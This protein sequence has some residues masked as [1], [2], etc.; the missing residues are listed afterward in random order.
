MDTLNRQS[1][2]IAQAEANYRN[3]RALLDQA[4]ASLWPTITT[5]SKT[6]GVTTAGGSVSNQYNLSASASWEVDLWGTVR[7]AVEAGNA[8]EAA[9]AAQL[10]PSA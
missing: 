4:E 2:T 8:K 1:P 6:R 9:S 5:A 10:A 7:R 3:A